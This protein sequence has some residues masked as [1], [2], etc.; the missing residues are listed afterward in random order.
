MI[1]QTFNPIDY[2]F[3]WTDDGWYN[4]D[5]KLGRKLAMQ[6][7][8]AAAKRAK[9]EGRT[10]TKF[11]MPNQLISR[12]GIGSGRPHIEQVVTCFG[13]NIAEDRGFNNRHED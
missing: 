13:V 11:S 1:Q 6:A 5:A 7:R 8:D 3:A 9:R 10:V 2:G 12:G 4:W